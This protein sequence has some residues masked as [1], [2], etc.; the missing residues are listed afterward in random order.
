MKFKNEAANG[1]ASLKPQLCQVNDKIVQAQN[2]TKEY[3]DKRAKSKPDF[4]N[5]EKVRLQDDD[6]YWNP[7]L[8]SSKIENSPRYYLVKNQRGLVLRRNSRF[9]TTMTSANKR[10]KIDSDSF[11]LWMKKRYGKESTNL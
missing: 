7:A 5:N 10:K 2:K 11:L 3:Y 1:R 6:K 9:I 8:V 4:E